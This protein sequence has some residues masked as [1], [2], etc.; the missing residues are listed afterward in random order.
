MRFKLEAK[1]PFALAGA[2]QVIARR[3]DPNKPNELTER[4]WVR[5]GQVVE[6]DEDLCLKNP[7]KWIR[8]HDDGG[9]STLGS[10]N[11]AN[12]W[13]DAAP[14]PDYDETVAQSGLRVKYNPAKQCYA[15][16]AADAPDRAVNPAPLHNPKAVG[17]WLA[18]YM[19]NQT[20]PAAAVAGDAATTSPVVPDNYQAP[21]GYTDVTPQYPRAT[22][23]GLRVLARGSS[24]YVVDPD[25]NNN[26]TPLNDRP[27]R[28]GGIEQFLEQYA[29]T[30]AGAL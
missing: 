2:H 5:R 9:Q 28:K 1:D 19:A 8:L 24:F 16:V 12:G 21:I 10:I 26:G 22:T 20:A 27:L 4:V 29:A 15:A 3:P 18:F 13:D 11:A 30:P 23:I 14:N 7:G 17:A 6:S 25:G